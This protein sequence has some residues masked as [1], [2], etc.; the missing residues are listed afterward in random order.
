[1]NQQGCWFGA[2]TSLAYSVQITDIVNPMFHGICVVMYPWPEK[3][4]GSGSCL[5]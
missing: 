4:I 5:P 1:M 3:K 2:V